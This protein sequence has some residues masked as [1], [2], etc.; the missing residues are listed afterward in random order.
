M[1]QVAAGALSVAESYPASEARGEGP[2]EIPCH[3][4]QELQPGGATLRLRSGATAKRSH[5][6]SKAR[7]V[8]GRSNPIPKSG[9]CAG[10]GG[11]IGAI[12]R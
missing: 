12:P 5:P 6:V 7:G 1:A 2:E 9:V 10:A 8:A 11:P 3:R 4:G